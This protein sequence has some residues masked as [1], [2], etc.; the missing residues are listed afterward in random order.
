MRYWG[1]VRERERDGK[2]GRGI[3]KSEEG[4]RENES[5]SKRV[6]A[7]SEIERKG[8]RGGVSVC[9]FVFKAKMR[10]VKLRATYIQVKKVKML[11]KVERMTLSQIVL[12]N[13]LHFFNYS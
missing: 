8:E 5:E 7:M 10:N 9:V 1:R 12:K 2:T 3:E 4:M 6:S 11:K 13:I